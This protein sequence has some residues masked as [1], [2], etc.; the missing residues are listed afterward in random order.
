[1]RP[2]LTEL[3]VFI[4]HRAGRAG[5]TGSVP[6]P[7]ARLRLPRLRDGRGPAAP[8][9]RGALRAHSSAGVISMFKPVAQKHSNCHGAQHESCPLKN[10][11]SPPECFN[12][13]D[14]QTQR[15]GKGA[16]NQFLE[17]ES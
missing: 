16:K 2:P 6:L 15:T 17:N 3:W 10:S 9:G 4:I 13:N 14:F 11:L 1:M 7:C 5:P 12:G 8:D